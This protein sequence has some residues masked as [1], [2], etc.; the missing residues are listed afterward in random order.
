ME[1]LLRDYKNLK[2]Q[3]MKKMESLLLA[4]R[5]TKQDKDAQRLERIRLLLEVMRPWYEEK[6]RRWVEN[7]ERFSVFEALGVERLEFNHSRFIAYFLDPSR[8]HDQGTAFLNVFLEKLEL[9]PIKSDDL[10]AIQIWPE[11]SSSKGRIDLVIFTPRYV[12]ALEN[13]VGAAEQPNQLRRY[14]DWL[15]DLRC[16]R[17]K[18]LV[19]LTPNGREGN[20]GKVDRVLSY[21][22][23]GKWF[24]DVL[25]QKPDMATAIKV[26]V[27]QYQKLC[28]KISKG[29]NA[30]PLDEEFYNLLASEANLATALEIV[31]LMIDVKKRIKAE[32]IENVMKNLD[33]LLERTDLKYSWVVTNNQDLIGVQT[34]DHNNNSR[35]YRCVIENLFNGGY[36]GWRR[37]FSDGNFINADTVDLSRK[38]IQDGYLNPEHWWVS[39]QYLAPDFRTFDDVT[40]IKIFRD[41]YVDCQHQLAKRLADDVWKCFFKYY[42]AIENLPSFQ[43]R[44]GGGQPALDAPQPSLPVPG[45]PGA[46]APAPDIRN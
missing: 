26:V 4:F 21:D 1:S 41:N 22:D 6:R 17:E 13:K 43:H 29:E 28:L 30:M 27:K 36:Y 46:E 8:K 40:V 23:L 25:D 35:N 7:A 39:W 24:G 9:K 15:N 19:F 42:Q 31:T 37:P 20:T 16:S 3:R 34:V 33:S 5:E 12:I 14:K 32:F 38:M 45:A 11:Y 44:N 10:S 2:Q 18:Y